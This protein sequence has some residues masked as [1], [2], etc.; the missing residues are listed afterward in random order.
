MKNL[1]IIH[2]NFFYKIEKC[3][4]FN[5]ALFSIFMVK[6]SRFTIQIVKKYR[7]RS[8]EPTEMLSA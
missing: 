8:I 4:L 3:N 6:D 2:V 7:V 1:R 5:V